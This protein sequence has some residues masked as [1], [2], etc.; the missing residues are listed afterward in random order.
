[1]SA[2]LFHRHGYLTYNNLVYE[3]NLPDDKTLS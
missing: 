3:A 1:M 2:E